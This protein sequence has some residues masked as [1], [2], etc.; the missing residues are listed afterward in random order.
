VDQDQEA[1]VSDVSDAGEDNG[2]GIIAAPVDREVKRRRLFDMPSGPERYREISPSSPVEDDKGNSPPAIM[3][4]DSE[5]Q[6]SP[7]SVRSSL[8]LPRENPSATARQPLFQ[9]PP[10]FKVPDTEE[11]TFLEGLPSVFSPQRKGAKY[12]AGG[13]A[14][15]VQRWLSHI[16]GS[17]SEVDGV[18]RFRVEE[19]SKDGRMCLVWGRTVGD[20]REDGVGGQSEG[21]EIAVMLAGQGEMTGL[22]HRVAVK[23]GSM[24]QAE[25]LRW[26]ITLDGLG[27]WV[28]VCDWKVAIP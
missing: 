26:R 10:R 6:D 8:D 17:R 13:L 4:T 19:M 15:E 25:G 16:K 12:V 14:A 5:A 9:P 21:R 2:S 24:I 22:G 28:V 23:E 20:G 18:L 27:D 7:L 3:E 11:N 1:I